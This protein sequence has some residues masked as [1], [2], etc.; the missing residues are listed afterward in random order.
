MEWVATTRLTL[1]QSFGR[2][3]RGAGKGRTRRVPADV[4]A[5]RSREHPRDVTQTALSGR[6]VSC[7]R[8]ASM[9]RSPSLGVRREEVAETWLI[10][11]VVEERHDVEHFLKRSEH[12]EDLSAGDDRLQASIFLKP[13]SCDSVRAWAR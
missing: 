3:D 8:R 1:V 4:L 5:L 12:R 13:L 2:G 6:A 7:V 11:R 9:G 10:C